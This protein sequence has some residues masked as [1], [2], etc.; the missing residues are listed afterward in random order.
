VTQAALARELGITKQAVQKLARRGMPTSSPELARAWRARNTR[1]QV[2]P[3][4]PPTPESIM[5]ALDEEEGGGAQDADGIRDNL[6]LLARLREAATERYESALSAGE[7]D[8]ARKWGAL[9]LALAQRGAETESK[10]RRLREQDGETLTFNEARAV[11]GK[12]LTE[13]KVLLTSM[14]AA[15]AA[16]VNPADSLHAQRAL[17]GWRDSVF[18]KLHG[19]ES[20]GRQ[21]K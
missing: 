17:E 6:A 11:F 16:Q 5:D 2:S 7:D 3:P 12:I 1:S 20:Q 4:R 13:I 8:N 9:L 19:A 10:L 14:P 21:P 15:M 18:R